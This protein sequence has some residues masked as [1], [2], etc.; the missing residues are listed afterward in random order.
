[1]C[2]KCLV[3]LRPPLMIEIGVKSVAYLWLWKQGWVSLRQ[4]FRSLKLPEVSLCCQ[5]KVTAGDRLGVAT[6]GRPL[7]ATED[8]ARLGSRVLVHRKCSPNQ[9]PMGHHQPL[10][11]ANRFFPLSN[12]PAEKPTMVIGDSVSW[13]DS[14]PSYWFI[15]SYR[16]LAS[17]GA[18]YLKWTNSSY[19]C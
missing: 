5:D 8:T 17:G 10:P 13:S 14:W 9:R 18:C 4:E 11:V 3:I 2:V 16:D 19:S 12:T 7:A 6:A 1:M 15:L